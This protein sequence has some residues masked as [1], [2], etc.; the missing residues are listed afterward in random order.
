MRK[1]TFRES[2]KRLSRRLIQLFTSDDVGFII[3]PE[4]S[5]GRRG[6]KCRWPAKKAKGNRFVSLSDTNRSNRFYVRHV[7]LV[8]VS[9]ISV[10]HYDEVV[11]CVVLYYRHR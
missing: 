4:Q 1:L 6:I 7:D 9:L 11:L 2:D 5:D 10:I 3:T 8:E